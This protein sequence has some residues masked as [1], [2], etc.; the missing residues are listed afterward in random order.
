M[1]QENPLVLADWVREA[2]RCPVTGTELVA[3]VRADGSVWLRNTAPD[4]PL[5]YPVRE[6]VPVLLPGEAE[7]VQPTPQPGSES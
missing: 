3:D 5:A 4:N 1:T 6:G 7:V 2:L